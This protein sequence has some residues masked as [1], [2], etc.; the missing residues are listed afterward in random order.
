[1]THYFFHLDGPD[2]RSDDLLG[3]EFESVEAAY[4]EA[5]RAALEISNE[6]L[7]RREDPYG[8]RFEICDET[9][10]PVLD[11]PFRELLRS[12][13]RPWLQFKDLRDQLAKSVARSQQVRE[14][15][16]DGFE[17]ARAALVSIRQTMG[18]P[19]G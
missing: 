7:A 15:L 6:M 11:I 12:P 5:S 9:L 13:S 14:E 3:C 19:M 10:G 16:A 1:M 4:L 17:E 8:L 18:Q 2:G